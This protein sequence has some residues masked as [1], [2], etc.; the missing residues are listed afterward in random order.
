MC[1]LLCAAR[2]MY[3]KK[4]NLAA[5]T[6]I[7]RECKQGRNYVQGWG[8]QGRHYS[9]I[10]GFKWTPWLPQK[11]KKKIIYVKFFF[12]LLLYFNLFLNIFSCTPWLKSCTLLLQVFST[13]RVKSTYMW[14]VSVILFY[15]FIL[16]MCECV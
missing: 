9:L 3:Y 5:A 1:V 16:Y 2:S 13:L 14:I 10:R 7:G 6:L 11:K 4:K 8:A 15:K 12:G